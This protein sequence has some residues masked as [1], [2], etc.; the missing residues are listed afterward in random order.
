VAEATGAELLRGDAGLPL[1]GVST[2][3]R[4]LRR[5]ELFVALS[6]PNFDGNRFA[7]AAAAA[8]A[9]AV[10]LASDAPLPELSAGVALLRHRSPRGALGAL[11]A[12]YRSVLSAR[13]IGVTG[14]CGKTT[15]KNVLQALL[16]R[17]APVVASPS[18]FNND[19]GVPLTLC[20]ADSTT[21][22]AVVEMGTNHPGEIAA[23]CRIARPEVGIIT[24]VGPSHLAGLASLA[25]VAREKGA[26]AEA[27]PEDGVCVLGAGSRQRAELAGRTRARV[28]TF[29]VEGG[30]SERGDLDA[31]R[32]HFHPGGTTFELQGRAVTSPLLGTHN[33]EN[34]LAALCAGIGLGFALEELLPAVATLRAAHARLERREL[35][36]VTL[37]DDCYNAN[38]QSLRAALGVLAGLEGH[39][40]RVL[41]MGDMLELGERS[42]EL[43][44]EIGAEVG[45]AAARGRVD[46]LVL[47]GSHVAAAA[48]G[49]CESGLDPA[50]LA[51]YATTA[52]AARDV[53][54]L[55]RAGDAV[56][57]KGSRGM[58]LERVVASLE[59]CFGPAPVA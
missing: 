29:S 52:E 50:A 25:G 12:W 44:R 18:S 31:R 13:V 23:L 53:G 35:A 51:H 32:L 59:A 26:L 49:A 24:N 15:T 30:G 57:V 14:S 58:G 2:D 3:S 22:L 9:A 42:A 21:R 4:S 20:L 37:L 33:V 17:H 54:A 41:V 10:L 19:I 55:V 40:R 7:G 38:P 43:H 11:G 27:L 56:L 28:L 8:G 16:A 47:V 6:G 46:A 34:L 36:G 1:A 48:A 39:R 5:G 45:R